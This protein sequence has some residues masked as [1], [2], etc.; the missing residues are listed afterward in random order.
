MI[1]L[2]L[3]LSVLTGMATT[4]GHRHRHVLYVIFHWAGTEELCP[5]KSGLHRKPAE[6]ILDANTEDS[7][8]GCAKNETSQ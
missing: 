6:R 2:F 3:L 5:G 1:K 4:I 7:S 8:F